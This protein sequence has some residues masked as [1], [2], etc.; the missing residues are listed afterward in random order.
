MKF[1]EL[2]LSGKTLKA[3]GEM[4]YVSPT[5]VQEKAI[6]R[7]IASENLIVR[8]QT[9]TGKT[10]AFGIGIIERIASGNTS[11]AL[12]L[13]PTRELAMQVADELDRLGRRHEIEVA[14][15]YGGAN[16]RLQIKGL[17]R[18]YDILVA[19]PGR[20]L[21]LASRREVNLRK[22]NAIVLDEADHM[23]DLGFQKDVFEIMGELPKFRLTLLFSATIDNKVRQ[24]IQRHMENP[25][26]IEVGEKGAVSTIEEERIELPKEEKM[27][28]L[29]EILRAHPGVKAL[30]FARTKMG[31]M[32]IKSKLERRGFEWVG[33]LQGNMEQSQRTKV[34]SR[35]RDNT[36]S[37]L[38]ATN[39][40]AR[41]L[42]VENVDLIVNFDEAENKETH[43]HRIG[44]TGRM[45]AEGKVITFVSDDAPPPRRFPARMGRKGKQGRNDPNKQKSYS[46][47]RE[48]SRPGRRKK[49]NP[50]WSGRVR[51]SKR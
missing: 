17:Q 50:Q 15:V 51:R 7:I 39:V 6:P 29:A 23:L 22:F 14:A 33:M 43:L 19:T 5:E 46:E 37:I 4:G 16:I 9:G 1:S 25:Q 42:H 45:G 26:T 48:E 28:K 41:G 8:S 11:K 40:A 24:I 2:K 31:V 30:I 10:A 34:I 49:R 3:I 21:D 13:V 44:R 18:G 32:R 47:R 12:I 27:G 20:L 36:I 38:V 35:F